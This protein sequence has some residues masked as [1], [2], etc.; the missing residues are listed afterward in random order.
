LKLIY[1]F[2]VLLILFSCNSSIPKT[3]AFPLKPGED[4]RK[5]MQAYVDKNNIKA[6]WVSSCVG[7]LTTYNIRFANQPD[8]TGANGHF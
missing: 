1:A 5:R 4:L 6:G 8:G 3:H 7:S 2:P